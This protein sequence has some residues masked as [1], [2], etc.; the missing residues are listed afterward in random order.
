[1]DIGVCKVK[2]RKWKLMDIG[3]NLG[4]WL[5]CVKACRITPENLG[6]V[7]LMRS[8]SMTYIKCEW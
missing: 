6:E 4:N 1:M 8:V 7:C 3:I 2:L 5:I